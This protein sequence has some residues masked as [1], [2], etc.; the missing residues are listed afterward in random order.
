MAT[1]QVLGV[2]YDEATR[3]ILVLDE[4]GARDI[5]KFFKDIVVV[6]NENGVSCEI[7]CKVLATIN[8]DLD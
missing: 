4:Y 2:V 8:Y 3:K 7:D 1:R 5:T 6:K